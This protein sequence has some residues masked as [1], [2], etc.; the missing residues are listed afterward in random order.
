MPTLTCPQ[1]KEIYD[2]LDSETAA[3]YQQ[4]LPID[5]KIE[6]E[7]IES[8][9]AEVQ[10]KYFALLSDTGNEELEKAYIHAFNPDIV[11]AYTKDINGFWNVMEKD[12]KSILY[13]PI[14][15]ERNEEFESIYECDT[16]GFWSVQKRNG[17]WILYHPITKEKIEE[18]K[19]IYHYDTNGF[20]LVQNEDGNYILYHPITKEKIEEFKDIGKPDT[21]GFWDVEMKDGKTMKY[22]PLTKEYLH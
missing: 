15:R 9:I 11:V 19:D 6:L 4:L 3:V 17:V 22:N 2:A 1:I 20:W 10:R 13:H 21:N 7:Y 8:L 12:D 16:H 14:T 5:S 18:F